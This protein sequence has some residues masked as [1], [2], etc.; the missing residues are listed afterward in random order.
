MLVSVTGGLTGTWC[1]FNFHVF[2]SERMRT[3]LLRRSTLC[4]LDWAQGHPPREPV[5]H[6]FWVYL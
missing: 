1:L 3:V 2:H 5:R 4:Q 6:Y